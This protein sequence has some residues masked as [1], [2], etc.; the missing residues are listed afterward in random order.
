MCCK[1]K[2]YEMLSSFMPGI[3]LTCLAFNPPR[4]SVPK[5][6]IDH[7]YEPLSLNREVDG[8]PIHRI[9]FNLDPVNFLSLS[10]AK[11]AVE[12]GRVLLLEND[13]LSGTVDG[14]NLATVAN[15]TTVLREND[16]ILA[17][18]SRLFNEYY[19]QSSTKNVEPPATYVQM[20][21]SCEYP[22]LYEDESI[23][24]VNKPEG[25]DTIGEKRL[26]LQSVLPFI[27]RPPNM[28]SNNLKDNVYLP[29]PIHRLDRGTSGCVLVA[30]TQRSMKHYSHMFATRRV[31]KTYCA[32]VF[33][34]PSTG[35]KLTDYSAIYYPIDG[36]DAIT[37]WK[38]NMTVETDEWGQLSLLHIVPKTGRYHQ[39]RRHLSYCLSC[40]IVGDAKYDGGGDLAK[41]SRELGL[42]LCAN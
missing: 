21:Q 25:I 39:I 2:E 26:D 12:Y 35:A 29:R 16:K 42:F 31:Q 15:S 18:R 17:I 38:V 3:V 11:R 24:I 8:L 37:Y 20:L 40:P 33:G 23:A 1:R 32:I 34:K 28:K 36:K 19:P 13:V 41:Q 6:G 9:L 27:L 7:I 5:Y 14:C 4:I 10:Q 30:K 22:V